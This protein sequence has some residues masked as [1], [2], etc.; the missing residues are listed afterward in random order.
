MFF[1]LPAKTFLLYF[2][3]LGFFLFSSSVFA[4]G[5]TLEDYWNGNANFKYINK[6]SFP[7][8]GGN[9]WKSLNFGMDIK[10]VG[11]TWYLFTREYGFASKPSYCS[12]DFAR[13]VVRTSTDRGRTWSKKQV[14]LEPK[15]GTPYECAAVDSYAFYDKDLSKWHLLYQCL[16]RNGSF[17]LCYAYKNGASPV[18]KFTPANKDNNKTPVIKNGEVWS[19]FLNR[20]NLSLNVG[21]EGTPEILY[22]KNGFFYVTLHGFDGK[23]GYRGLFKTS[24]FLTWEPAIPKFLYSK[25]DC[26]F[27]VNWKDGG[28]I[29]G[30]QA[31]TLKEGSNYYMLIE[32]SDKNLLCTPG[33]NWVYGLLRKKDL[34]NSSLN[35]EYLSDGGV[36]LSAYNQD[37]NASCGV[38]YARLFKDKDNVTYL[39]VARTFK[40]NRTSTDTDYKTGIYLY[41]LIKNYPE[42]VY[43]L[44]D[45]PNDLV[46]LSKS[47]SRDNLV[48]GLSKGL[49]WSTSTFDSKK[50]ILRFKDTSAVPYI[51]FPNNPVFNLRNPASLDLR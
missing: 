20:N 1:K 29:G 42:A 50:N 10:V 30:G 46:L 22:K 3:L 44:Q 36:V 13:L 19:K 48:V 43:D 32:S 25:E 23:N 17:N 35:W 47:V 8:S 18:G 39:L 31:T 49:T 38:Q 2:A 26:K 15:E 12:R 16:D 11:N 27:S 24:D 34:L 28:C 37:A 4:K 45:N 14:V 9:A 41:E 40:G 7:T 21:D 6:F 51:E 33:Q 5:A